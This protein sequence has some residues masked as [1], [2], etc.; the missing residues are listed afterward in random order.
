MLLHPVFKAFAFF[1]FN[2][3]SSYLISKPNSD[4]PGDLRWF[5]FC[6]TPKN[7]H[8]KFFKFISSKPAMTCLLPFAD[9][10]SSSS[11]TAVPKCSN[12][13]PITCTVVYS[14]ITAAAAILPWK[15]QLPYHPHKK[16]EKMQ[17]NPRGLIDTFSQ[18]GKNRNFKFR[19]YCQGWSRSKWDLWLNTWITF[20][21]LGWIDG[22]SSVPTPQ[23]P[24]N[25]LLILFQH[26]SLSKQVCVHKKSNK[27]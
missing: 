25:M 2:T 18:S 14:V 20:Q 12:S 21:I 1:H 23:L 13:N 5:N 11:W 19:P 4:I 10:H 6:V 9:L 27:I 7:N 17:L 16:L 26:V 15:R 22:N 3:F 24:T 8:N